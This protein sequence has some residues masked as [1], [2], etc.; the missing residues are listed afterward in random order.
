MSQLFPLKMQSNDDDTEDT[1]RPIKLVCLLCEK[2]MRNAVHLPCCNVAACRACVLIKLAGAAK[3]CMVCQGSV[4]LDKL[5]P[6]TEIRRKVAEYQKS[7]APTK[8]C[9]KETAIDTPIQIKIEKELPP[10][11]KVNEAP[12]KKLVCLICQM[13]GHKPA[14]CPDIICKD[15]GV[16]GHARNTCPQKENKQAKHTN[17]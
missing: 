5:M 8:A 10:V 12:N 6:A 9:N 14:A 1:K 7:V 15:C 3:Q 13:Y 17:S 4:C 2:L 16:R 11:I